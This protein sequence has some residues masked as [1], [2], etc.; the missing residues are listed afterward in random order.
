ML[1]AS[2]VVNTNENWEGLESALEKITSFK[3]NTLERALNE[4]KK[5]V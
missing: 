2:K 1:V 5:L 3:L 4:R